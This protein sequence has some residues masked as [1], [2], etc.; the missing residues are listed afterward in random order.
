MSSTVDLLREWEKRE[1]LLVGIAEH[2]NPGSE[3]HAYAQGALFAIR[4]C[5]KELCA[6][7]DWVKGYE[8]GLR[9]G[10]TERMP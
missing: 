7:G 5:I 9:K 10:M 3:A 4:G 8:A 6:N 2:F 1:Q